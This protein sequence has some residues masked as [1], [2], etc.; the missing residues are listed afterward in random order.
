MSA[1]SQKCNKGDCGSAKCLSVHD[2]YFFDMVLQM[3]PALPVDSYP[4]RHTID[5]KR[6][7]GTTM[8][9]YLMGGIFLLG[10]VSAMAEPEEARTAEV[11]AD[12][13]VMV[14][15]ISIQDEEPRSALKLRDVLRQPY[16]ELQVM[17]TQPYRLSVEERHRMREQLR[18]Q[19]PHDTARS[20][21]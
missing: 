10:L 9:T 19:L 17:N 15:P 7:L 6:I 8:K 18:S 3:L 1:T 13:P 14:M 12:A 2:F 4:W 16:E 20:K 21:P 5:L 11:V